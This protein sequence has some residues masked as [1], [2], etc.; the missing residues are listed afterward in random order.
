[1]GDVTILVHPPGRA[2]RVLVVAG[3]QWPASEWGLGQVLDAVSL[4]S[5]G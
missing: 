5:G 2:P 1:M 3:G 4:S